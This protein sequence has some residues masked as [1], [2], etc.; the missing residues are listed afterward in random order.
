M[1]DID[2]IESVLDMC[3]GG[4]C[5]AILAALTFP[6]A[7]VDAV[8]ISEDALQVAERNVSEYELQEDVQLIKSNLF[9]QLE[10][11][12][13]DIIISN[14]PYV[15]ADSVAALPPE[16]LQEP[17]LALGSGTDGLDATREILRHA[18][19]H[20]NPNGLLIV[21]IGHNREALE[22]AFPDLPFVWLEVSAGDEYVFLLRHEDLQG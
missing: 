18:A 15:D 8:D 11:R 20:L 17:K 7:K 22:E 2:A 4:G 12:R 1:E 3:C 21:E 10:G 16:Y 6:A 19:Q 13:Y 5:L 14:P 9:E